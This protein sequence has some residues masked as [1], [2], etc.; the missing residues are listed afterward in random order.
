MRAWTL[1]ECH[2][3]RIQKSHK[4]GKPYGQDNWGET[5]HQVRNH[6]QHG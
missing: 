6:E 1:S 5:A 3:S 2:R 4:E